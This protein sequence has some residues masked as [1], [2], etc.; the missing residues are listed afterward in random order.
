[1][2][3]RPKFIVAFALQALILVVVIITAERML[4]RS[5]LVE[6][7]QKQGQAIAMTVRSTAGYYVL[8]GLTDDLKS[9]VTELKAHNSAVAYADF[10]SDD[11]K[12][13]ASSSPTPPAFLQSARSSREVKAEKAELADHTTVYYFVTPFFESK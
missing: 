3:L 9:I 5:K 10:I 12:I 7:V 2:G 8:F 1:M 13:L 4:I 11:G 6:Q